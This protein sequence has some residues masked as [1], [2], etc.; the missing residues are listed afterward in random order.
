M[1]EPAVSRWRRCVRSCRR[2]CRTHF[3]VFRTGEFM[4][5]GIAKLADLLRARVENV[6]LQTINAFNTSR[7]E[8]LGAAEPV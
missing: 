5:E 2:S 7:I 4:R 1:R 3:G 8:C 6:A